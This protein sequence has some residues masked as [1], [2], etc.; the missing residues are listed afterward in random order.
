VKWISGLFTRRTI[1]VARAKRVDSDVDPVWD[2]EAA[3]SW[4]KDYRGGGQ[5]CRQYIG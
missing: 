3:L 4:T 5:K 2:D 1:A